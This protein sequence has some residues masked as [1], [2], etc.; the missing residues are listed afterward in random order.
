M[1][2]IQP[3]YN[4][5]DPVP[6]SYPKSGQFTIYVDHWWIVNEKGEIAFYQGRRPGRTVKW[7]M[8]QCN[9]NRAISEMLLKNY[10]GC[11]IRQIYIVY[12]PLSFGEY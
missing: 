3:I 7:A 5:V 4:W 11:S 9:A 8:P 6:M 2:D 1:T 12:V 10:P